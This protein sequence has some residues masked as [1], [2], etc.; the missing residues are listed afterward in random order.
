MEE[1]PTYQELVTTNCNLELEIQDLKQE[2]YY[3]K[4][5]LEKMNIAYTKAKQNEVLLTSVLQ[6]NN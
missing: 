1:Q 6:S 4:E 5:K 2:L 3:I